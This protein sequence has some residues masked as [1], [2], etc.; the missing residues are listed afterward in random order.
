MTPK[1]RRALW[2]TVALAILFAATAALAADGVSPEDPL[3]RLRHGNDRFV[4]GE[5][6]PRDFAAERK[7]L[8]TEQH[9]YAIVL[10][11]ADSRVPPE[12][13]FDESLGQLFVVRV[14]GN[15]A[16]PV[17][18]GSIEYAV[19]HLGA[20]LLV[21]LGHENCGAVKAALTGGDATS[22]V[23]ALVSRIAPAADRARSAR[24]PEA[25]LLATAVRENVRYQTQ[26]AIYQSEVLAEFV[27]KHQLTIAG[28]VYDLDTGKVD[29]LPSSVAVETLA[30]APPAAEPVAPA[31]VVPVA[32]RAAEQA[33]LVMTAEAPHRPDL[34]DYV[35]RAFESEAEIKTRVPL[36]MR[37]AGNHCAE[38]EC[39]SIPAGSRIRIANPTL[40]ASGDKQRILVNYRGH[41]Y[42]VLA[43]RE[44][45]AFP[46]D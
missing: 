46:W 26:M 20:H 41:T 35:R 27:H 19:E 40:L 24:V 12:I 6:E 31:A 28:G 23:G 38:P 45:L 21:V 14:A 18:L 9:P 29:F 3:T 1:T 4:S 17:V 43:E 36:L 34:A 42:Y 44:A 39:K 10:A 5:I 2:G 7:E 30:V 33:S 15:V 32:D 11:C 22:N 25:D 8:A 16:D 37:D 13:V